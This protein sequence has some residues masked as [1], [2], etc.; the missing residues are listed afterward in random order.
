MDGVPDAVFRRTRV[1]LGLLHQP[2]RPEAV[3]VGVEKVHGR[4]EVLVVVKLGVSCE[5]FIGFLL[6]LKKILAGIDE[7]IFLTFCW[8]DGWEELVAPRRSV[9]VAVQVVLALQERLAF[10]VVVC[11]L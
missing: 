5:H 8:L 9:A 7:L 10:L 2:A 1:L 4:V 3:V 11:K 6:H